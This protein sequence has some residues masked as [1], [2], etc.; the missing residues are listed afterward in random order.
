MC[1]CVE[2]GWFESMGVSEI[3]VVPWKRT[4]KGLSLVER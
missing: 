3:C 1:S 4:I 2:G